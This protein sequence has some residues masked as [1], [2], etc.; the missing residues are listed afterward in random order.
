[1]VL[2]C[3]ILNSAIISSSVSKR[4]TYAYCLGKGTGDCT[5][6]LRI[7]TKKGAADDDKPFEYH[8]GRYWDRTSDFYRVKVALSR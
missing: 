7:S 5:E 4:R 1:M 6:E 3:V 2:L 8:G